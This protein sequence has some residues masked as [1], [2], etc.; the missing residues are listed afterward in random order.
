MGA[1]EQGI[2]SL[3]KRAGSTYKYYLTKPGR[4]VFLAGLKLNE[5]F[6]IPQLAQ[7][8]MRSQSA[9]LAFAVPAKA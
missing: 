2:Y 4:L 8:V 1:D 5:F 3:L 7:P 9:H 6:L